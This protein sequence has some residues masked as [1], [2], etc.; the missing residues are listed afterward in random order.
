M[1][2]SDSMGII[3]TIGFG[4]I[5]GYFGGYPGMM[6]GMSLAGF[7]FHPDE[8]TDHEPY[9]ERHKRTEYAVR[10]DIVPLVIGTDLAPGNVIWI[11]SHLT[12]PTKFYDSQNNYPGFYGYSGLVSPDYYEN[13]NVDAW[14]EMIREN[15]ELTTFNTAWIAMFCQSVAYVN[16]CWFDNL[17]HYK[18]VKPSDD[19][20]F[21]PN[22]EFGYYIGNFISDLWLHKSWNP[23]YYDPWPTAVHAS[24]VWTPISHKNYTP[25]VWNGSFI[26]PKPIPDTDYIGDDEPAGE[27]DSYTTYGLNRFPDLRAEISEDAGGTSLTPYAGK[28]TPGAGFTHCYRDN[29][30][31]YLYRT[32]TP[33]FVHDYWEYSYCRIQKYCI[34]RTESYLLTWNG[35]TAT[36]EIVYNILKPYF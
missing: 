35:E 17:H 33:G 24:D 4:A 36:P 6:I 14:Y 31:D 15:V 19:L 5:G 7:L 29:Q 30:S 23:L 32:T 16:Q 21:P 1:G 10:S 11:A 3:A 22:G 26:H 8:V 27:G 18:W 13:E 34:Q 2:S 12:E 25:V 9:N 28:A 20:R